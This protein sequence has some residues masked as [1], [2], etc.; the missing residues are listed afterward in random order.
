[1]GK[2]GDV[3]GE[4]ARMREKERSATSSATSRETHV[5]DA[6]AEGRAGQR[7]TDRVAR[8][9]FVRT[10]SVSLTSPDPVMGGQAPSGG[11]WADAPEAEPDSASRV[12]GATANPVSAE[13]VAPT[14]LSSRW[15]SP[16]DCHR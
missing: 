10:I 16:D 4:S 2:R 15:M 1:M 12:A 9:A 8:S 6:D 11:A 13:A 5:D 7:W 3:R 14:R